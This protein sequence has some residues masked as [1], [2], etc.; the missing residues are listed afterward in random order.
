M[1]DELLKSILANILGEADVAHW[2]SAIFFALVGIVVS[3]LISSSKRDARSPGTPYKF[4]W[5]YLI[6]DNGKRIA[7][8]ILLVFITLRFSQE[9]LSAQFTMYFALGVGL[10]LDR[11]S[12]HLQAA[13]VPALLSKRKKLENEQ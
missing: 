9:L 1:N 5:R 13:G 8:S 12:A 6:F 4:S 10:G 11:L 2:I 7:L 3:L